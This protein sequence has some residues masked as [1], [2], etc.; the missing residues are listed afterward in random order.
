[1]NDLMSRARMAD[2]SGQPQHAGQQH[3]AQPVS[4]Q[5]KSRGIK[6]MK[7]IAGILLISATVLV[8][9]IL[10]FAV[11][12]RGESEN[13]LIKTEQFQAVFLNDQSGQVYFGKLSTVNSRLYRLTDIYYV[14]VDSPVQPNDGEQ[15]QQNISLAKLGNELHGPEDEMFINR[16]QVL[17]WENLKNDG[18]VVTAIQEFKKNGGTTTNNTN[19]TNTESTGSGST[20]GN[21]GT[22]TGTGTTGSGSTTGNT[23]TGTGTGTTNRN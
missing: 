10:L 17:F 6:P 19:N 15:A 4:Q 13:S 21:T 11:F 9:A 8:V 18:Q 22:G 3:A 23:G 16:D 14:R 1:M 5:K 12:G 2:Q 7:I 20:T